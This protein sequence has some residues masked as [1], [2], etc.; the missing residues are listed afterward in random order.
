MKNPITIS[1]ITNGKSFAVAGN[2]YRIVI[3]GEETGGAYAVIDMLVPPGGGPGPHEH[4][5]I[6]ETFYV[7]EGEVEFA[8]ETQ[9][10]IAKKGT[11]IN[12]PF[13]G[14]V[15][16]FKNKSGAMA[17]LLCTVIPSGMEEMFAQVGQPVANGEFLPAPPPPTPEQMEQLKAVF[18]KYG[19]KIYP[20]DYLD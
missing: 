12:I 20:P 19:S 1:E 2:S 13:N 18:D 11:H 10:Y 9:K 16:K 3:S 8:N 5:A 4:P 7:L 6:N 15:H 17:R 14:P